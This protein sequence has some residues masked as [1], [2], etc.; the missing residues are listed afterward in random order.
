MRADAPLLAEILRRAG[1]ATGGAV[2]SVVLSGT[3]GVSRG[4]DFWDDAV[5]PT[6]PNQALNRVQRPG[7]E[8]ETSLESWMKTVGDRPLFAF[9]HI[10]EPHSPYDPPEPFRSRYA[11]PY[12]GEVAASDA[13]VGRFLEFLKA[14]GLYDRALIVFLSDHGEGLGDHGEK[15][16]G[17]FLYREVLQVPLLLKL[18]KGARPGTPSVS[19]PVHLTDVFTTLVAAAGSAAPAPPPGT[20]S[21]LDVARGGAVPSRRLY[22]ETFF[23]RIHFGWSE[24]RSLLD[25]RWH[26]VEAP[27]SELYDLVADPGEKKDLA[28]G[29]SSSVPCDADR[30]GEAPDRIPRPRRR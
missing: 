7:G 24:L 16:H 8:T 9:L 12:D 18:P 15:E 17:V 10:Y 1:Y 4:F 20:V 13:I 30:D 11:D 28:A 23:P 2:S 6:R 21:L 14:R 3:S 19:T 5:A 29:P 22:A 26:Y 27:R 25:D